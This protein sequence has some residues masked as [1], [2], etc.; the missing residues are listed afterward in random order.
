MSFPYRNRGDKPH[1]SGSIVK[2]R[3]NKFDQRIESLLQSQPK[4]TKDRC[5]Q[6]VKPYAVYLFCSMN[7]DHEARR[8]ISSVVCRSNCSGFAVR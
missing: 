5:T 6:V 3:P 1:L 2:N 8:E 4:G 7:F